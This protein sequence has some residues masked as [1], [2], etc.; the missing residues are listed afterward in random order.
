MKREQ[1]IS[2]IKT[3]FD[4]LFQPLRLEAWEAADGLIKLSV[5][6]RRKRFDVLCAVEYRPTPNALKLRAVALRTEAHQRRHKGGVGVLAAH[7]SRPSFAACEALGLAC[8]DLAGTCLLDQRGAYIKV[9]AQ[10]S[11]KGQTGLALNAAF[12]GNRAN[13]I[14]AL[15]ADRHQV[16]SISSLAECAGV[17]G[18]QV[19][20]ALKPLVVAGYVE[21]KRGKGGIHVLSPGAILDAWSDH[22]VTPGVALNYTSRDSV[23]QLEQR[24]VAALTAAQLPYAFTGFSGNALLAASGR[25]N[26]ASA[27]VVAPEAKLQRLALD[28]GLFPAL[29]TAKLVLRCIS[30]PAVLVGATVVQGRAVASAAQVY[31]D[32]MKHVQRGPEAAALLRTMVMKF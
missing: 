15:L 5:S 3:R 30:D 13:V 11:Q 14:R 12:V 31:L 23:E 26:E 16:W 17:S 27:Y 4:D 9:L 20:K 19:S 7:L 24:L 21:A 25:Y 10:S 28:L 1:L 6:L 22:Y 8:F 29:D 18:G 32:L 2:E